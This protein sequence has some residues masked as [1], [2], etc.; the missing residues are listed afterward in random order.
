VLSGEQYDEDRVKDLV[1]CIHRMEDLLDSLKANDKLRYIADDGAGDVA[2][3]NKEI[4]RYFRGK[5]L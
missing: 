5:D 1:E 4:A 2:L 3:W